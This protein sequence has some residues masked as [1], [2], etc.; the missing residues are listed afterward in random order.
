MEIEKVKEI[1]GRFAIGS[2]KW[3]FRFINAGIQILIIFGAIAALF[4]VFKMYLL[5]FLPVFIVINE[6]YR[7]LWILIQTSMGLT[8][9]FCI[10]YGVIIYVEMIKEMLEERK[11]RREED[12]EKFLNDLAKKMKRKLAKRGRTSSRRIK[13]NG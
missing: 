2:F 11:I 7:I 13:R 6:I 10:I 12:K 8:I 1:V 4:L 9:F 5:E 3:V